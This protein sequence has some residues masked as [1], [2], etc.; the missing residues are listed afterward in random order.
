LIRSPLLA[1]LA[2]LLLLLWP[3]SPAIAL[4][5]GD[6]SA[7][8]PAERVIDRASVLSRSA[9]AELSRQLDS[10][11]AERVDA[12]L[13]TVNQLDYG[14][15]LGELGRQ[16]VDRWQDPSLGIA[17]LL[18]LIDSQTSSA[19]V[20]GSGDLDGKL[21]PALLRS[22][23]RTTMALPIREGARY[24][25]AGIDGITRLLAV[26]QGG[27]DPGEPVVAEVVAAP[28]NVPSREDTA[29]SNALTWVVVLLVVG[30]LV[31]MATWWVFSR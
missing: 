22:T 14:L 30:T 13:L 9:S 5:A 17:Q 23:A 2:A 18:F 16:L 29:S 6:F 25:Q 10:F 11:T 3:L 8:P 24:R 20:V 12:R 7:T 21:S 28:S 19:A 15:S 27:E 31:P 1:A 4:S 26:L